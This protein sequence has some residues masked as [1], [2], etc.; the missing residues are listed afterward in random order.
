[1]IRRT[2]Q[3]IITAM[4]LG[5][6]LSQLFAAPHNSVDAAQASAVPAEAASA[7]ASSPELSK[8]EKN[9]APK[10]KSSD[11][12][13]AN[14]KTADKSVP[15]DIRTTS[16]YNKQVLKKV[17]EIVRSKLYNSDLVSSAWVPA[18]E[19]DRETILRSTNLHE[20]FESINHTLGALKSSH[21]EFVTI[22]DEIF[23]FLHNMFGE[24][25]RDLKIS[26]T[27]TGFVVGP[28][29]FAAN[30]VRYVLDDS[31]ASKAGLLVGDRILAVNGKPFIGE[32]NFFNTAGTT[33]TLDVERDGRR[34]QVEIVPQKKDQY[35]AY[36]DAI[37]KSAKVLPIGQLKIGYI[38]D[39]CGGQ[40]AHDAFEETLSEKLLDTDG[41]ILDLRDGYGGND[42]EDLEYLYRTAQ[43]YPAFMV[44]GRN[45][46][47]HTHRQ[48]YDKPVVALINDGS[49]SG[50]EL[51]A[52]SLKR[53]GRARLVGINTAGAF[54]AGTLFPID[55]KTALYLAVTDCTVGG[56]RLEAVG[57]APDIVVE[58]HCSEQ[59]KQ[60]QLEAAKTQLLDMIKQ[61]RAAS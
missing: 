26:S 38:R 40:A 27:V 33:V 2:G 61:A 16:D 23:Y 21:C 52:F 41:L 22:N 44:K 3:N 42:L 54:L 35:A 47:T 20:L 5:I 34:M 14:Q 49:R 11:E 45:G 37:K 7:K 15:N 48:Y 39:W 30:Q 55:K 18:V 25:K 58:D 56:T 24:W 57:V 10:T 6:G 9:S 59:G 19:R 1:M 50:K 53:T 36:V 31:P 60:E 17:D 13:A 43:A 29:R 28:P 12:T 51:L 32:S 4:V 46:K 8:T